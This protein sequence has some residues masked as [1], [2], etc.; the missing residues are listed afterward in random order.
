MTTFLWIVSGLFAAGA[1]GCVVRL[2]LD[3]YEWWD[4][5]TFLMGLCC[6]CLCLA[7]AALYAGKA[8][9]VIP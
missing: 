9:G 8:A 2:I 6:V 3:V 7:F 1:I 4:P 5:G